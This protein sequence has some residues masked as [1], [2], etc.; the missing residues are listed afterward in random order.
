[1]LSN[2]KKWT[3]ETHN[4]DEITQRLPWVKEVS[5]K[6]SILSNHKC[7]ELQKDQIWAPGTEGRSVV[8][9][10]LWWLGT[11]EDR[12]QARFWERWKTFYILIALVGRQVYT[13]A[14]LIKLNALTWCL[15]LSVNYTSMKLILK[16]KKSLT[17][18]NMNYWFFL[19]S[20]CWHHLVHLNTR[21]TCFSRCS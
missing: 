13:F 17:C 8:S 11:D 1:M 15:L 14:K 10:G 4:M 9:W 18:P 7:L 3:T 20:C 21:Q 6:D 12:T 2:K 5:P 19:K 16:I